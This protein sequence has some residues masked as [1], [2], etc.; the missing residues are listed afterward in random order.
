VL[1]TYKIVHVLQHKSFFNGWRLHAAC[2][3]SANVIVPPPCST[4]PNQQSSA[5]SVLKYV[6]GVLLVVERACF[7]LFP[8]TCRLQFLHKHLHS[9]ATPTRHPSPPNISPSTSRPYQTLG[10]SSTVQHLRYRRLTVAASRA[11]WS[12]RKH[13][14]EST[15][16]PQ[17]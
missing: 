9:A 15:A 2:I 11:L 3:C 14:F 7:L 16:I 4:R 12:S 1:S 17:L 5:A 10:P 13:I 6:Q 8:P